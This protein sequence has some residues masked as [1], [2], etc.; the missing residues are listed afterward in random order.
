MRKY[1]VE[2][3]ERVYEASK[4]DQDW[5]GQ[6]TQPNELKQHGLQMAKQWDIIHGLIYFK[7]RLYLPNDEEL[8][9]IIAKGC[10]DSQMAGHLGQQ[11]TIE[12]VCRDISWR[13]LQ[14]GSTTMYCPV[15]SANRINHQGMLVFDYYNYSKYLSRHGS[16]Y[17]QTSSSNYQRPKDELR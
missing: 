3:I 1:N 13:G 6:K 17:L 15:M 14:I 8:K 16:R 9:T 7:N 11:N 5:Q 4:Q 10:H 12:I 2:F